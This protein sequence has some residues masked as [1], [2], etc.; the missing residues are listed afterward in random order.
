M[1]K[2]QKKNVN[3]QTQNGRRS[4]TFL[5][6]SGCDGQI[7]SSAGDLWP[8]LC[9]RVLA[10]HLRAVRPCGAGGDDARLICCRYVV[11]PLDATLLSSTRRRTRTRWCS[12][13][14]RRKRT[15]W[16]KC[17]QIQRVFCSMQLKYRQ[18]S[19]N[20]FVL[21]SLTHLVQR[22]IVVSVVLSYTTV[23]NIIMKYLYSSKM[24]LLL[25]L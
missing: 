15:F 24:K 14:S 6:V 10:C 17:P 18:F 1:R 11:Q 12:T 19:F 8:V 2:S 13:T 23:S 5:P 22:R 20:L 7:W 9:W 4:W 3:G 16:P 21:V 25:S